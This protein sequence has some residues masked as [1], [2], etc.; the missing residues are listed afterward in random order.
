M[1]IIIIIFTALFSVLS[2]SNIDLFHKLKFNAW[3]IKTK[4]QSWR[5][6]TYALVHAGWMH[7][8]INM[9]VLYSFG[10]NIEKSF[11]VIF[12]YPKGLINYGMLYIGGVLFSTL[13]DYGKQKDNPYYD[14][15]GASGAV[16]AIV[17]ASILIAPNMSLFLFPIPFPIPAYIF[18]GLYLAYSVYMGKRGQDNIGH[19]AHFFGAIFGFGFTLILKPSLI[20]RFIEQLLG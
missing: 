12:G 7:L 16:A 11:N 9:F 15:V 8:A 4:K 1:T 2:F 17:F 3:L 5:F 10:T 13:F 19:Y 20:N 14:A 18:G 6:L